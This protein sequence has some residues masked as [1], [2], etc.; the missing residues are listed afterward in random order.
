MS[1]S[2]RDLFVK[3]GARRTGASQESLRSYKRG[4]TKVA[5]GR[6]T[7]RTTLGSNDGVC[8]SLP[9]TRRAFPPATS[10]F[11]AKS[12]RNGSRPTGIDRAEASSRLPFR[13]RLTSTS[14]D[15]VTGPLHD[16]VVR[17]RREGEEV[18]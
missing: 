18:Q 7:R 9:S 5:P 13:Q 16:L 17:R 12:R 3:F 1:S 10:G 15:G 2:W 8:R 6:K 14:C 4:S 11:D